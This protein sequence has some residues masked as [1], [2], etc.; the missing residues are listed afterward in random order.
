MGPVIYTNN[1]ISLQRHSIWQQ[2]SKAHIFSKLLS[3]F[4]RQF[5]S[6]YA[7]QNIT[8]CIQAGYI[9]ITGWSVRWWRWVWLQQPAEWQPS[10]PC[11]SN[12]TVICLA[13]K[14]DVPN[15]ASW[16]SKHRIAF[17]TL[18]Q[19]NCFLILANFLSLQLMNQRGWAH[20]SNELTRQGVP[21]FRA[22][23]R[24][25]PLT[26]S[27]GCRWVSIH[28]HWLHTSWQIC[29]LHSPAT[30]KNAQTQ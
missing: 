1:S 23:T 18:A 17:M 15:Y 16:A 12:A 7:P 30:T 24:H 27:R 6:W 10:Q 22:C 29:R 9:Q 14:S 3:M 19:S 13:E 21:W 25:L 8:L 2:W 28:Q 4:H 26:R 11:K 20:R 5:S